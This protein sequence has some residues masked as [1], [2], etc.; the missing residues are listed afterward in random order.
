VKYGVIQHSTLINDLNDWQ[1]LYVAG[2]LHK[3]VAILESDSA[4]L[5][6]QDALQRNLSTALSIALISMPLTF[7]DVSLFKRISQISY[8][9]NRAL[10]L[11]LKK[12]LKFNVTLLGDVRMKFAEN[13]EKVSNIVDANIDHFRKLYDPIIKAH[14]LQNKSSL[15]RLSSDK[16][17]DEYFQFKVSRVC[18]RVGES[19]D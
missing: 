8:S 11:K 16:N 6:L 3:P 4:A 14:I 7:D 9:G 19:F 1:Q 15:E 18:V 13:P 12:W 2:R 5:D 17:S 10:K